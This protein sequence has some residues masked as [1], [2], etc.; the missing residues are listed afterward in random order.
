IK[1]NPPNGGFFAFGRKKKWG[2]STLIPIPSAKPQIGVRVLYC[3]KHQNIVI[4]LPPV[5]LSQRSVL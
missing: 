2:Q 3:F 1:K 4:P 5:P